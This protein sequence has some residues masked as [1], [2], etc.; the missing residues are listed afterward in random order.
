MVFK[1][2]SGKEEFAL[3]VL[4]LAKAANHYNDMFAHARKWLEYFYQ[5]LVNSEFVLKVKRSFLD[6]SLF[7]LE[8]EYVNGGSR[9][10]L[11]KYRMVRRKLL[12]FQD[13]LMIFLLLLK[14]IDCMIDDVLLS[15]SCLLFAFFLFLRRAF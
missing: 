14:G 7:Y 6:R 8:M 13:I 4:D 3:K 2:K 12:P 10:D 9:M 15:Y 5:E 11:I 1:L